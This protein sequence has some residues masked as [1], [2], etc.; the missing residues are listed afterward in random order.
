MSKS[1]SVHLNILFVFPEIELVLKMLAPGTLSSKSETITLLYSHKGFGI[2]KFN[3][4]LHWLHYKDYL[5]DHFHKKLNCEAL[6]PNLFSQSPKVHVPI[7]SFSRH[8]FKIIISTF[9]QA[10]PQWGSPLLPGAEHFQFVFVGRD[11]DPPEICY[12]YWIIWKLGRSLTSNR[13]PALGSTDQW[14][15]TLD[16]LS[17]AM[18]L[19]AEKKRN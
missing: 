1:L 17:E 16:K 12:N 6:S 8:T 14:P 10:L 7:S 4:L 18:T 9:C 2:G 11:P 5:T 15:L 19:E 13:T 3:L